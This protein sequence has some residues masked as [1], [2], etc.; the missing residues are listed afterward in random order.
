MSSPETQTIELQELNNEQ[1][2]NLI[3][4][5]EKEGRVEARYILILQRWHRQ[6]PAYDDEQ[7]YD[8]I[9][10]EAKEVILEEFDEGYPYRR[11]CKVA[12]IPLS[13]PVI[14]D[15]H[16]YDNTTSPEIKKR[17]LYV[18]TGKEWKRIDLY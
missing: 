7:T 6:G 9:I 4:L 12:I 8:I 17:K 10:G 14:I 16:R 2:K 13:V 11:G 5:A 3:E 15:V 1:I 18:F